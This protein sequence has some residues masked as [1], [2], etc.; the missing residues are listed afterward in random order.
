[1]VRLHGP[2]M[3]ILFESN[4]KLAYCITRNILFANYISIFFSPPS[5]VPTVPLF[6]S[7]SVTRSKMQSLS[8]PSLHPFSLNYAE[9]FYIFAK[10]P[11]MAS[12][13]ISD[14]MK[15]ETSM[16]D[17][18][19]SLSICW[20]N[21]SCLLKIS[22]KITRN[23]Y[24]SLCVCVCSGVGLVFFVFTNVLLLQFSQT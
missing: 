8:W 16:V 14:Y 4:F 10:F 22:I 15:Y 20:K 3:I 21:L 1:M 23:L 11:I 24:L 17:I 6:H 5:R 12:T 9:I 18:L 2:N 7:T 13:K 19:T